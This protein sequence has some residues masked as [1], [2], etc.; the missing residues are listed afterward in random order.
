MDSLV[1]MRRAVGYCRVSTREQ[2]EQGYSIPAQQQAIKQYCQKNDL[3]LVDLYIDAGISGKSIDKRP[4]MKRLLADCKNDN[5]DV[6]V[7]WKNSRIARNLKN[8]LQIIDALDRA[9]VEFQSITE[10]LALGTPSGR[11]M[12]QVMGSFSE[13]ERNTI[14]ENVSL[15]MNDRA[16]RGYPN[17]G[18]VLGYEPDVDDDGKRTLRIVE[19]EAQVIRYIFDAYIEGLGYRAIANRVNGLGYTT[20]R[21]NAFSTVAVKDILTNPLYV[22]RIRYGQYTHWESKRRRGKSND[23]IETQGQHPAIVTQD[24]WNAVA[25]GMKRRS[26]APRWNQ[27]GQNVLTGLLRCPACGQ[28][29]AVTWTVNKLKDGTRKRIRYYTCSQFKYKGAS[30]C[31][32]NSIRADEA[33]ALVKEKLDQVLRDPDIGQAV[34]EAM[35]S[36]HEDIVARIQS[37]IKGKKRLLDSIQAKVQRWDVLDDELVNTVGATRIALRLEQLDKERLSVESDL[38]DA[39][40][41]LS[42]VTDAPGAM[43]ITRLLELVHHVCSEPTRSTLKELYRIFITQVTF[44]RNEKLVKVHMRFDNDIIARLNQEVEKDEAKRAS[45]FLFASKVEFEF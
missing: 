33:E 1:K 42:K 37:I 16:R 35:N 10:P 43:D 5:F 12:L 15:G 31:H 22:G 32:A 6:V 40:R 11:M 41:R 19:S 3:Q 39:Q 4:E 38:R 44:D 2:S 45:S 36:H 23:V 20:K 26:F 24:Q 25:A 17:V 34:V 18:Q 28:A 14:A 29:M 27:N 8:L 30:V 13:F 21:N 7:V 9:N